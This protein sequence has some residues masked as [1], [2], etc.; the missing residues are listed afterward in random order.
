LIRTF[1]LVRSMLNGYP[2]SLSIIFYDV[3]YIRVDTFIF[4]GRLGFGICNG[5]WS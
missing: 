4:T 5:E 1:S 3:L 2:T